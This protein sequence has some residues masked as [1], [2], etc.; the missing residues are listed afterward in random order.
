MEP[1][2]AART[3]AE[4][5][6]L[7]ELRGENPFK[8]RAFAGAA[9]IIQG[10]PVPD[11]APLVRSRE[12][13]RLPGVGPATVAVLT[14]LIETGDSEYLDLLRETTPEGLFEMLRIPGLGPAKIHKLHT[15]L[16]VESVR[17]LEEAARDGRLAALRGFGEKTAARILR[18]IATL[19]ESGG[20]MLHSVAEGE[21]HRLKSGIERHPSVSRVLIAGALRRFREVV[22][23]LEL[24]V[25]CRED[26]ARVAAELAGLPHVREVVSG[27]GPVVG[28]RFDNGV[29]AH[30]HCVD[31]ARAALAL[32]RAT[33]S[34]DHCAAIE[35][36][37][38]QRGFRIEAE[39]LRDA[40]G[41]ERPLPDEA[42][43]YRAAGADYISPELRENRGEIEAALDGTLPALL[44]LSD[45]RGVLHC[46]S[47]YSDG[48]SSIAEMAEAA[49]RR[50]WTYLGIT[51]HSQ[52]AFYAGGLKHD[53]ILRQ[54]EEIDRLN[55]TLGGFRVLKGIEAD[56]LADG[57]VDYA[58]DLLERFDYVV[59]SVHSRFGMTET[60]MTERILRALEDP[61]LT[62]LGHPTG[63]LLLT[64]EAYAVNL[65][66]VIE[67]A[68]ELGVTLELNC[69]PHRL[70]LDW[71][72]LRVARE[73]GALVE[74]GP[75]A[76]S[77]EGLDNMRLG[78]G[79]A[80]KAWLRRE[81]VLN[82]RDADAVVE[83]ARARRTA[84][85]AGP[86]APRARTTVHGGG[87]SDG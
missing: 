55:E 15:G 36:L 45:I 22:R 48:T 39:A 44:E 77:P 40:D 25:V 9:R 14:D 29:H 50:G 2:A 46:H 60:Q 76:H 82:T 17:D 12:I 53:A 21:A 86:A 51:D 24:V 26:P 68:V 57:R 83:V 59:G 87:P 49:R 11:V 79:S 69:D 85:P 10:L 52:S 73:R 31:E 54:H 20:Q 37:L 16:G 62:I 65:E 47:Q 4:I 41:A 7:L 27:A 32:W 81:D 6:T 35:A 67:R 19:R 61:R 71:R 70:D 75:D 34:D 5:A 72:W 18:G 33:G 42:A 38:A 64:R 84:S 3:L 80:R 8:A 63:R 56:I 74:I 23:D 43:L 13:E 28:L 78:V 30:L 58:D 1:R 66:A